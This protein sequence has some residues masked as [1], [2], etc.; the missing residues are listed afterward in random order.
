MFDTTLQFDVLFRLKELTDNYNLTFEEA[1]NLDDK[2]MEK[3][4]HD[5]IA[6][7]IISQ[8]AVTVFSPIVPASI[9]STSQPVKV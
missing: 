9:V 5:V 4:F 7:S 1:K 8:L 3:F 2:I 6:Y